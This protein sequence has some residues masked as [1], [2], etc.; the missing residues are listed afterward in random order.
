MKFHSHWHLAIMLLLSVCTSCNNDVFIDK[1]KLETGNNTL[2]SNGDKSYIN[3]N[4][5]VNYCDIIIS[6][7]LNDN[8]Q[9]V[10]AH[11]YFYIESDKRIFYNDSLLDISAEI[12][13]KSKYLLELQHNYY[14]DTIYIDILLRSEFTDQSLLFKVE[15]RGDIHIGKIN[16]LSPNSWT[17]E[18]VT[19]KVYSI[20]YLNATDKVQRYTFVGQDYPFKT[21]FYLF[22]SNLLNIFKEGDRPLVP[23]EINDTFDGKTYQGD[24]MLSEYAESIEGDLLKWESYQEDASFEVEPFESIHIIQSVE[25]ERRG[26]DYIL[27]VYNDKDEKI[28]E[29]K[30]MFWL[31]I[32]RRFIISKK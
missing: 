14:P 17:S 25:I 5:D 11:S 29:L 2:S 9:R 21:R 6:R 26:Y 16:F 28:L 13:D 24:A 30:G 10:L 3:I 15:P 23:F 32:P 22:D 31:E 1:M 7:K 20:A 12:V 27:P 19:E 18:S 4:Q 8:E